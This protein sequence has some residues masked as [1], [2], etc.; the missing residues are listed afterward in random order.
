[1]VLPPLR[2]LTTQYSRVEGCAASAP[3]DSAA[4]TKPTGT[5][6]TAA[7]R[8]AP[9]SI[10]SS[11]RNSAVGALPTATT[12]PSSRSRHSSSAAALRVVPS[13][14]ARSG[15]AGSERVQ[16]TSLPAG[17]RLRVTP[18]ATMDTS[19]RT[20]APERR[21][22]RARATTPAEYAMSPTRSTIPQAW[23]IRTATRETSAGSPA[24][25]ASARMVAKDSR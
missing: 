7:G 5:P 25:S 6:M 21:A 17:S 8:G 22:S 23:I 2:P 19:Q 18:L 24:R 12:A 10:I 4:P 20:G 16:I 14:A 9:S 11:S 13:F 3:F 15:T 1:M